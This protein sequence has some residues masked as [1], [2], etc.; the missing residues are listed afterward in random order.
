MNIKILLLILCLSAISCI[1]WFICDGCHDGLDCAVFYEPY[2]P[3][4][5]NKIPYYQGKEVEF[6]RTGTDSIYT[7]KCFRTGDTVI[8]NIEETS[9]DGSGECF[10]EGD[11]YK[12]FF[13]FL[14]H[15]FQSKYYTNIFWEW[16]RL[17]ADLGWHLHQ[18]KRKHNN[19]HFASL[20]LWM[21]R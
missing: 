15:N 10:R 5:V 1:R 12:S 19:H 9:V 14:E 11:A 21:D 16:I 18:F 2:D 6:T 13:Y 4:V 8:N 3:G 20:H 17:L 7:L